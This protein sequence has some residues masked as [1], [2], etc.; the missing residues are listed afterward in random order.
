MLPVC[1]EVSTVSYV[2][3][4]SLHDL[5]AALGELLQHLILE[6]IFAWRLFFLA[7]SEG[8]IQFIEDE[9]FVPVR[10]GDSFSFLFFSASSLRSSDTPYPCSLWIHPGPSCQGLGS[11]VPF[12]RCFEEQ[13]APKSVSA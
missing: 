7:A 4:E 3:V 10:A 12:G 11:G 2:V 1:W 9:V 13:V 5:L 6:L 8:C